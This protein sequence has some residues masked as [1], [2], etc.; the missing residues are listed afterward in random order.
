MTQI[1]E[2]MLKTLLELPEA[3]R[4][5]IADFLYERVHRSAS[6]STTSPEDVIAAMRARYPGLFTETDT[7]KLQSLIGVAAG[8]RPPPSDAEVK[9]WVSEHRMEKYGS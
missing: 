2:N 8:D 7:Q 3:Q 9:Q 4:I 5:D 6:E 1:A